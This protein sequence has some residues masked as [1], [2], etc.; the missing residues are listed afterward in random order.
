MIEFI[1]IHEY[2]GPVI[3]KLAICKKKLGDPCNFCDQY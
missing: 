3:L 2:M 1:Y